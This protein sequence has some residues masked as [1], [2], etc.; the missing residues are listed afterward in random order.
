MS[1]LGEDSKVTSTGDT[2][3]VQGPLI[4]SKERVD[5][6]LHF[7][8]TSTNETLLGVFSLLI[9]VTYI[10]LGRLGLLL[11]GVAVGVVLHASWEGLDQHTG[12]VSPS[13]KSNRRRELSLEVSSRLI[14]WPKRMV[15]SDSQTDYRESGTL[16]EDLS[17]VD[18][19]YATFQPATAGALR[20]LTD[21]VIN[22][23]VQ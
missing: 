23:Y 20:T 12:E 17:L 10:I 5:Y 21:A 13:N 14:D 6:I 15:T 3:N 9:L 4:L 22:D 16:P 2:D 18:L 8:S 1:R 11:I 7:L 19:E